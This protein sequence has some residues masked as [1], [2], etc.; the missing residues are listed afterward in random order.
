MSPGTPPLESRGDIDSMTLQPGTSSLAHLAVYPC[1]NT[2]LCRTVGELMSASAGAMD[3]GEEARTELDSHAN[4]C[5]IGQHSLVIQH[6]GRHADVNTFS[7]SVESLYKVP[8]VDA[9]IAYDCPYSSKTYIHVVR[10]ALYVP[11]MHNNLIPPFVIRE[12]CVEVSEV[13]KIHV[14]DP[15]VEDHS[16]Y[17]TDQ[18]LRIP[19][20]LWGIFSYFPC[21][22]PCEQDQLDDNILFLTPDGPEWNPHSDSYAR[23]E[24][25]FL[26]W[27][28]DIIEPKVR[29]R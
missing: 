18:D 9:A 1:P 29:Q 13:P 11:S 6:S 12:A 17:F 22:K 25:Q 26:D 2:H 20:S 8:I 28:G 4:M 27:R 19:L 3:G 10:N 23:N 15:T 16:I 14:H 24:E 5:V 7:P 21:R